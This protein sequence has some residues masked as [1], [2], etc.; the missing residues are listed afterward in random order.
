M[1]GHGIGLKNTLESGTTSQIA[2][3]HVV[4]DHAPMLYKASYPIEAFYTDVTR[5]VIA[6]IVSYTIKATNLGQ[7]HVP[8]GFID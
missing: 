3:S 7:M 1:E 4:S 8:L 6:A 2:I 5:Y